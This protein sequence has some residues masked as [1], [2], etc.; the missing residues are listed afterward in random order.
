MNKLLY[1]S[2]HC[3]VKTAVIPYRSDV[4]FIQHNKSVDLNGSKSLDY[5]HQVH[6]FGK[7]IY[8]MSKFWAMQFAQVIYVGSPISPEHSQIL[9]ALK[10]CQNTG[11]SPQLGLISFALSKEWFLIMYLQWLSSSWHRIVATVQSFDHF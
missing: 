3:A 9:W 1:V 11:S 4:L 8:K 6:C 5:L 7:A 10:N 2:G